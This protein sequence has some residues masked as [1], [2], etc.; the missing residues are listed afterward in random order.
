MGGPKSI[1][2]SGKLMAR[3][4]AASTQGKAR[5]ALARSFTTTIIETYWNRI[6]EGASYSLALPGFFATQDST[7]LTSACQS[8][9]TTM[10]EAAS[11]LDPLAASY[12]IS[13][14]YTAMLSGAPLKAGAGVART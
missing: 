14:T 1:L 13:V 9:A 10:G 12:L 5:E 3:V 7:K 4:F 6:Q 8:L 2:R 11:M